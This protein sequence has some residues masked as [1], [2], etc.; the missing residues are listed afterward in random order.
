MAP[1]SGGL[2]I[3]RTLF[4]ADVA[5]SDRLDVVNELQ[6]VAE[7]TARNYDSTRNEEGP[8]TELHGGRAHV[9]SS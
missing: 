8:W 6:G 2:R 1:F 7:A 5:V 9:T 4:D 3:E